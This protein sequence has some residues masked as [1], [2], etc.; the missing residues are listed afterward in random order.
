MRIERKIVRKTTYMISRTV[1]NTHFIR[2]MYKLINKE[3]NQKSSSFNDLLH[4]GVKSNNLPSHFTESHGHN[5]NAKFLNYLKHT[6]DFP[7]FITLRH[8]FPPF[9]CKFKKRSST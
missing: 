8:S 3:N 9:L 1:S 7:S 2:K 4:E 6:H 5:I